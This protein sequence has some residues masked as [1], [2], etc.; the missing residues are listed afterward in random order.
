MNIEKQNILFS[1]YGGGHVETLLPLYKH[2]LNLKKY[3]LQYFALTTALSSLKK[4][5]ID[6]L[7]YSTLNNIFSID[8]NF[9]KKYKLFIPQKSLHPLI[10]NEETAAYYAHNINSLINFHG[11]SKA[12]RLFKLYNRKCFE[13]ISLSSKILNHFKIDLLVTTNSPRTETALLKAAKLNNIKSI[14]ILD[15]F[16]IKA[17]NRITTHNLADLVFTANQYS[18]DYLKQKNYKNKVIFSGN[19]GYQNLY[20]NNNNTFPKD[21]KKICY[22][23]SPP[24]S[25]KAYDSDLRF[26]ENIK[27]SSFFEDINFSIRRHPSDPKFIYN[28]KFEKNSET[29]LISLLKNIDAAIMLV[30]SVGQQAKI[31]S[32]FVF[33]RIDKDVDDIGKIDFEQ[34]GVGHKFCSINS[35]FNLVKNPP[36]QANSRKLNPISTIEIN[37]EKLLFK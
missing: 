29:E 35:L 22:F 21:I 32:K 2:L 14:C 5:N 15:F 7:S 36:F 4:H 13:P 6:F 12:I 10:S 24:S 3:N 18:Y 20:S 9:Y 25:I 11:E 27:T 8:K 28:S 16:D 34:L 30:S 33:Q 37:I 26:I 31:L 1:S 17:M 19:P 23:L